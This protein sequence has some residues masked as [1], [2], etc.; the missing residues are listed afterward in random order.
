MNDLDVACE[1]V[2]TYHQ[3]GVGSVMVFD[4][5]VVV[6]DFGSAYGLMELV[7]YDALAVV[8]VIYSV[9]TLVNSVDVM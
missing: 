8:N 3:L 2:V 7:D 4:C 6:V 5:R 9:G 1:L